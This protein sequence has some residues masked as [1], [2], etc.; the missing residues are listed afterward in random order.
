[1]DGTPAVLFW[2]GMVIF[3]AALG[4]KVSLRQQTEAEVECTEGSQEAEMQALI[5]KVLEL[6]LLPPAPVDL[7]AD[8]LCRHLK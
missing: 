2:G 7:P 8:C 6:G 4:T 1:M 5:L 3:T